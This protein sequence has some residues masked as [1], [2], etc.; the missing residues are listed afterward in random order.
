[1]VHVKDGVEVLPGVDQRRL[2]APLR[3]LPPLP[4]KKERRGRRGL[5]AA[6]HP[7]QNPL[8]HLKAKVQKGGRE[9]VTAV[10]PQLMCLHAVGVPREERRK[11]DEVALLEVLNHL[12]TPMIVQ[13]RCFLTAQH[14]RLICTSAVS[15]LSPKESQKETF[16]KR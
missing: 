9:H 15:I 12:Q 8:V 3:H 7:L 11:E 10:H 4:L 1:M 16:N 6:H 14:E 5:T 2:I 13:V